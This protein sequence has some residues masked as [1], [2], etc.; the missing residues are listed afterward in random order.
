MVKRLFQGTGVA[1]VTPFRADRS[2]DFVS[3]GKLIEHII[4][5]KVEYIVALG[6][7]GESV[8]LNFDEKAAVINFVIEAVNGRVPVVMGAGG[9]NTHEVVNEVK[10][11]CDENI[12]VAGIL[13]VSPYY[14]KPSQEGIYLH[15]KKIAAAC[16]L[17]LIIYNVPGRTGS[18]IAA[19]TTL[20]LAREIKSIV[21]IKEASG[22]LSQINHILKN[23]P[24]DFMVLSG[25]DQLTLPMISLGAAGAISVTANAFPLEFSEMVRSA[26]KGKLRRAQELQNVLLD[27]MDAHFIE[28]N[29]AGVKASLSI[30]GLIDNT[31]RLPLYPV[32]GA[33]HSKLENLIQDLNI[34]KESLS[35]SEEC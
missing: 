22:N 14:N 25:D 30:K 10:S 32:S 5:G 9:N 35:L 31:L 2:V 23:K 21:A 13:S 11:I 26:L 28:G 8:T 3:M 17:P 1:I 6:T 4:A 34:K 15:Y 27:I 18:N 33:T 16:S 24:R 20:Q 7:T 29:P 19:S 12:P